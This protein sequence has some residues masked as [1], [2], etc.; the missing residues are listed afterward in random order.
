MRPVELS[1]Q[2]IELLSM[3]QPAG[4]TELAQLAAIP[5]S[6][7]QRTLKA[8]EAVGWI[9]PRQPGK[10]EWVLS[11]RALLISG[12]V[13][14]KQAVLR[15]L[16]I[17]VM[18]EVRRATGE[19]VHLTHRFEDSLVLIERLDGIKPVRNFFARGDIAVLHAGAAG[20]A[21][22]AALPIEE[23]DRYLEK[24]LSTRTARTIVEPEALAEELRLARTLGYATTFGGNVEDVHAVGAAIFDAAGVANA[25]IS[26]SAPSERMTPALVDEVGPFVADAARRIS[27]GVASAR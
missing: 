21:I 4:V 27:L 17:P 18:E 6:T 23:L 22:L 9:E 20:K 11:L 3:H 7:A 2:M 12:R 24:P 15:S 16:A 26:I 5:K 25:A 14:E 10:S 1:F 8:L 19:T 13:T